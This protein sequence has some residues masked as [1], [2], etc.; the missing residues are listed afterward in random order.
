MR[1]PTPPRQ[2]SSPDTQVLGGH[3]RQG[4]LQVRQCVHRQHGHPG[5]EGQ[6]GQQGHRQA[7]AV[8]HIH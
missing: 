4:R 3:H 2:V 8:S 5:P 7:M 1:A 6:L